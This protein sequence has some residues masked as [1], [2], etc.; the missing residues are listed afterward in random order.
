MCS[1]PVLPKLKN[2]RL[3]SYAWESSIF[4]NGDPAKAFH[5][6]ILA[7]ACPEFPLLCPP[8]RPSGK[9]NSVL[10]Y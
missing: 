9:S 4:N 10:P 8:K 1:L 3:E 2:P 7:K 5:G 6:G